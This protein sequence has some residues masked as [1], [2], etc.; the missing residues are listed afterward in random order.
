MCDCVSVSGFVQGTLAR[1][2]QG[3]KLKPQIRIVGSLKLRT[4]GVQDCVRYI[5]IAVY[6]NK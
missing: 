4:P 5:L 3:S 6:I 2:V 1:E